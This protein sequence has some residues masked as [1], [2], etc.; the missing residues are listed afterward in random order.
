MSKKNSN[1]NLEKDP[2]KPGFIYWVAKKEP[3]ITFTF[4]VV[5]SILAFTTV[6]IARQTQTAI[7]KTNIIVECTT[8][9]TACYNLTLGAS[10]QRLKEEKAA[11]FCVIDTI[12]V[13]PL[14]DWQAHRDQLLES[15][16]KC[17]TETSK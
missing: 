17:V 13:Y 9:G 8:P 16:N 3:L 6:F 1:E 7:N 5:L 11:A 15:Y 12:T 14:S 4:F 2:T 10:Q